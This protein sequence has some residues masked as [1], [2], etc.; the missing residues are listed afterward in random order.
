MNSSSGVT[1]DDEITSDLHEIMQDKEQK[2]FSHSPQDSFQHVLSS[3]K[4]P[5]VETNE[6]CAGIPQ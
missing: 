3:R 2:I 4:K 5:L 1:L 6:A